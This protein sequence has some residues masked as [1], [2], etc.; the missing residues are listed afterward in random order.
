MGITD[1][2]NVHHAR[3]EKD[4]H[5]RSHKSV[6]VNRITGKIIVKLPFK[7]NPDDFL[8]KKHHGNDNFVQAQKVYITQCRIPELML[9]GMR[10]AHAELVE[11]KFMVRVR[12]EDPKCI[13]SGYIQSCLSMETDVQRMISTLICV[14][15]D[16]TMTELNQ[17]LAKGENTLGMIFDLIIWSRGALISVNYIINYTLMNFPYSIFMDF[18]Y[19]E[20]LDL[21]K[22][23]EV[24]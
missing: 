10:W 20:S 2:V 16:P 19:H 13:K 6:T 18:F 9:G 22:E 15:V 17:M 1:A 24:W 12:P 21:G 4:H 8:I 23:P 3:S 14:V 11:S 5:K 7:K